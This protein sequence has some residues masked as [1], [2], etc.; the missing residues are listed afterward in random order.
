MRFFVGQKL[1][2]EMTE[3]QLKAGRAENYPLC[4]YHGQTVVAKRDG[5]DH[6]GLVDVI[7]PLPFEVKF[8]DRDGRTR[9]KEVYEIPVL[10]GVLKP[11]EEKESASLPTMSVQDRRRV[12]LAAF[13][14]REALTT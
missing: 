10:H 11:V 7:L 1:R 5:P 3:A 12:A 4:D 2:V 8:K 14:E 9:T 13:R 6:E